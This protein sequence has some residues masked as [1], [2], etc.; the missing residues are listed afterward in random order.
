MN[1][2]KKPIVIVGS[3]FAGINTAFNLKKFDLDIPIIIIDSQSSFVFKPLMYEI[4]SGEINSWE[5]APNLETIFANSGITFLENQL[6]EINFSKNILKFEDDLN[7]EYQY[8]VLS[9]GSSPNNFSIKGVDE[10]CY[11]FNEIEDIGKL[12]YF[13]E[14]T[15]TSLTKENIFIIGAGPSGVELACKLSDLYSDNFNIQII[16]KSQDILIKNKVFNREEAEKAIKKRDINVLLNTSVEEIRENEIEICN[17]MNQKSTL[18]HAAVIWTAG[19]K[20]NLPKFKEDI[21]SL[22]GKLVINE[23]LQIKEFRN[24]FALGDI[25]IIENR[26]NLPSTAQLAM[27]QGKHAARNLNLL[28]KQKELLPFE[29]K[30]NGEMISLG[31]GDAS[32]SALGIT[33]SGKFAFELRRLIYASKM[34]MIEKTIKSAASWFIDKKSIFSKIMTKN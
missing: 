32:I 4:L 26:E 9:T 21:T 20:P 24:V 3:G 12:K 33:L 19:V 18:K 1:G 8:L 23:N 16:E 31:V 22:F 27:Q 28:I 34:P 10:F 13:L 11:F 2:I 7:I 25:S 6:C 17:K 5:V 29:F 15:S 30:D 14:R